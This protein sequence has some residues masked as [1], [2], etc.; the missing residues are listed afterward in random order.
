MKI[1][2]LNWVGIK[3]A[4]YNEMKEAFAGIL[5]NS[6]HYEEEDFSVFLL[7]NG[8]R[9]EIFGPKGL[10]PSYKFKSNSVVASFLVD[11]MDEAIGRL[12]SIGLRILGK[13]DSDRSGY[14]WQHFLM[15]DNSVWE[16]SYDPGRSQPQD[17]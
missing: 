4:K 7:S 3:S 1:L 11:D 9:L 15:P 16:I 12:K 5:S 13:G 6:P 8:D 17:S 2:G 10:G 14:R